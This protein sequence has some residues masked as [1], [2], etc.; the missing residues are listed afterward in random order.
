[1]KG[2]VVAEW[3]PVA[4]VV[5]VLA[6]A[7]REMCGDGAMCLPPMTVGDELCCTAAILHHLPVVPYFLFLSSI[8]PLEAFHLQ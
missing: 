1:M 5:V 2:A 6:E 8:Y 4:L 3:A 7:R